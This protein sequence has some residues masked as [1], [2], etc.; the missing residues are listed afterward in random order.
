[1][2]AKSLPRNKKFLRDKIFSKNFFF[3]ESEVL[4][5]ICVYRHVACALGP[6]ILFLSSLSC[7]ITL[8][9]VMKKL[10]KYIKMSL[11]TLSM[12]NLFSSL[13]AIS[14]LTYMITSKNHTLGTCVILAQSLFPAAMITYKNIGL[15]SYLR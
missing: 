1:M 2:P 3:Q 12:H 9:T 6:G 10:H 8:K 15:L 14:Q 13:I 5:K 4:T 7:I 11:M